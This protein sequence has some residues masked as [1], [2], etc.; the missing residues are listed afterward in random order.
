M[1]PGAGAD[2]LLIGQDRDPVRARWRGVRVQLGQGKFPG[3]AQVVKGLGVHIGDPQGEAGGVGNYL[4]IAAEVAVLARAPSVLAPL[5]APGDPVG[6]HQGAVQA[7]VGQAVGVSTGEQV[8]ELES[9]VGD[10]VEAFVE[11]PV[12]RRTPEA[13]VD[14]Q[15]AQVGSVAQPA[16]Y[17]DDLAVDG[18]SPL[19]GRAPAARRAVTIHPVTA[20]RVGAGTSRRAG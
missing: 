1:D 19:P 17:Q 2:V 11:I 13:S 12:S 20:R 16:H 3:A 15:A 4:N 6:G 8:V 5:G 14:G 10:H 7:Q 9:M 18:G